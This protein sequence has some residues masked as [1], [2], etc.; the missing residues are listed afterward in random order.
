[1]VWVVAEMTSACLCCCCNSIS[2]VLYRMWC[3]SSTGKEGDNNS[4]HVVNMGF[5]SAIDV[6]Y[7]YLLRSVAILCTFG[8][9]C[10][11]LEPAVLSLPLH[12]DLVG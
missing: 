9:C 7:M 5:H 3:V 8:G 12:Y 4:W 11:N 6:T 2:P 1:M 10:W